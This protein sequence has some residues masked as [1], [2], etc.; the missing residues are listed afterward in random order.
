MPDWDPASA[1]DL[2]GAHGLLMR[3]LCDDA[4]HWRRYLSRRAVSAYGSPCEL[5]PSSDG[6]AIDQAETEAHLPIASCALHY[7]L[8]FFH[9]FSDGNGRMGRLWQMVIL[10]RWRPVMAFLPVCMVI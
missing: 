8:E 7:E 6:A 1:D 2:L 3:G 5:G 4:G 9:P 10:S